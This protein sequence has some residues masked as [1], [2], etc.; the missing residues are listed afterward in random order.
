MPPVVYGLSSGTAALPSSALTI[1]APSFSASCSSSSPRAQRA[2]A[3]EDGDLLAGVEDVGR[4][5]QIGLAR[6]LRAARADVG[7]VVRH[8]ALGALRLRETSC[9]WKSVG[10]VMCATPR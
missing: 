10:K 1:G 8:V 4:A 2:V 7:G 3:G 5:A 9:S 6:Q